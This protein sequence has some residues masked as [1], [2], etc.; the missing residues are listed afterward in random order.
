[1]KRFAFFIVGSVLSV[2][3]ASTPDPA[4]VCTA[5]W[6]APRAERAVERI[7]A[8]SAKAFRN[9]RKA[10]AAYVAGDQPGPFTLLALRRSFEDLENELKNGR[11]TKDLR[12]LARTCDDPELIR[13]QVTAL[14]ERQQIPD[15]VIAFLDATS[16][17]DRL[18]ELAEGAGSP[19]ADTSR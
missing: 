9:M 2:G 18:I 15:R 17:L 8:K 6:I 12:T 19:E 16:L 4:V 3:C 1:M 11:G 5:E 14:L 10:G 7:E 13:D